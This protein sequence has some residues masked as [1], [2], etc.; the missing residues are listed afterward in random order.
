MSAIKRILNRKEAQAIHD[1]SRTKGEYEEIV[2]AFFESGNLALDAT[3]VF[4]KKE[5]A[6]L[7]NNIKKYAKA[8]KIPWQVVSMANGDGT[9][10]VLLINLDA[11]RLAQQTNEA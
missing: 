3:E 4:P 11:Y 10:H 6:N 5:E 8:Q 1:E 2:V 9:D 7:K